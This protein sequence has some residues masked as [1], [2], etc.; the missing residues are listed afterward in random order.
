MNKYLRL[1]RMASSEL[2]AIVLMRGEIL[3]ETIED[4]GGMALVMIL[5]GTATISFPKQ[6]DRAGM[7]MTP[8]NGELVML[9]APGPYSITA[10]D[11]VVG[12]RYLKQGRN[13]G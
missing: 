8:R 4:G 11:P 13:N 6:G 1:L 9:T 7:V 5:K 10:R 12:A 2:S 3:H